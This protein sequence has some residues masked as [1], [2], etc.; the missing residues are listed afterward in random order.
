MIGRI[1]T[2][3]IF[4]A[5]RYFQSVV[6]HI[7]MLYHSCYGQP[8][9]LG[10]ESKGLP[11]SQCPGQAKRGFGVFLFV[12][13]LTEDC[14]YFI[15]E[16]WLR[17]SSWSKT[18]L[19]NSSRVGKLFTGPVLKQLKNAATVLRI[20][21]IFPEVQSI[22][23]I[24]QYVVTVKFKIMPWWQYNQG[25]TSRALAPGTILERTTPCPLLFTPDAD[26]TSYT[27]SVMA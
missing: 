27:S 11:S 12:C 21:P 17:S 20:E 16:E 15:W 3:R 10:P 14:V 22:M 26:I 4:Q 6:Y 13:W 23:F 24:Y 19:Q 18:H 8:C 5:K 9:V 2:Q 1:N 25:G 7:Q